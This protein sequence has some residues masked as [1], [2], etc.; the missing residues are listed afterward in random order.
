MIEWSTYKIESRNNSLWTDVKIEIKNNESGEVRESIQQEIIGED[1]QPSIYIWEDGN[2]SCDC[3]RALF[4]GEFMND[5]N[6]PDVD[7]GDV[8]Y[9]VRISH[10]ESGEV[11]YN[12]FNA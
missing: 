12:E 3:N 8:K 2:F 5:E 11:I 6:V 10:P 4:F 9:S 1:G 7:C